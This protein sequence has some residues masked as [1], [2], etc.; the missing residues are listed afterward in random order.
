[1]SGST[2]IEASSESRSS[3]CRE[4]LSFIRCMRYSITRD[5]SDG[6]SW[7]KL[8][9]ICDG[10]CR[11]ILSSSLVAG[12]IL[13]FAFASA[14]RRLLPPLINHAILHHKHD[15]LH[16]VNLFQMIA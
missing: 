5:C 1:M 12:S 10:I 14:Q 16:R 6:E 4:L 2:A 8:S 7:L 9:S 11:L 13:P 15:L 3:G